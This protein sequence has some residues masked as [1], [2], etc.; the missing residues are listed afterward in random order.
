MSPIPR[1]RLIPVRTLIICHHSHEAAADHLRSSMCAKIDPQ[2]P[3]IATFESFERRLPGAAPEMVLVLL[4]PHPEE[5][6][7]A[8]RTARRLFSGILIAAGPVSDPQI[9]LRALHDGA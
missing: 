1:K 3:M 9:I 7:E 2:G 5:G 6:L 4:S 8:V